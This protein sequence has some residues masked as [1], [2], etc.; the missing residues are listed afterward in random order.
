M[1][2]QLPSILSTSGLGKITLIDHDVVEETNL[3]R[4]ILYTSED[5]GLYK[6]DV[7]CKRLK[8]LNPDINVQ[9]LQYKDLQMI[10]F[11]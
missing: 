11:T 8:V 7:A 4:Q 5:L 10:Q 6:A 2:A 1:V 3:Q 9:G